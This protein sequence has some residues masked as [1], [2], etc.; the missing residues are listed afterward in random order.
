VRE[1]GGVTAGRAVVEV[2]VDLLH[3][4][5]G[6]ERVDRHPHLAA[7]PGCEW[8]AR[9]AGPLAQATLSGERLAGLE[10]RPQVDELPRDALG[11][12]ESAA[13]AMRERGHAEVGVS[14][15]KGR[16]RPP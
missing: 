4:Q 2:E 15:G 16:Q 6:S 13:H 11:N 14:L 12:A 9:G 8:E 1:A 7:E 3:A 5:P 10:A